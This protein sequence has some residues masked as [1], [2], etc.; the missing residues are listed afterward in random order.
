MRSIVTEKESDSHPGAPRRTDCGPVGS[1]GSFGNT[2]DAGLL[3]KLFATRSEWKRSVFARFL[4]VGISIYLLTPFALR[5][6]QTT[7]SNGQTSGLFQFGE[8]GSDIPIEIHSDNESRFEGGVAI[9]EKNVVIHY[10]EVTLYSDYAE[11][12]VDTK[13]VLLRGNVRIFSRQGK[14]QYAF[15]TDRAVYN[16]DTKE[17]RM[18]SFGGQ[19]GQK[20][21][22]QIVGDT[23]SSSGSNEYIVHNGFF[24]TSDSSTPDYQIRARTMRIYPDDRIILSNATMFVGRTP[25]F[26]FPYLYQSLNDQFSFQLAPGYSS[27]FGAYMLSVVSFPVAKNVEASAHFDLRTSRGPALGLDVRYRLGKNDESFG[28]LQVYG[29]YDTNPNINETSLNRFPIG[30]G[31]YR[32]SYES[33]TYLTDDI[34]VVANINKFSD[35]YFLQDFYPGEFT[36]DPQPDTYLELQKVGEAYTLTALLRPQ[37]NSFQETTERLP[38]LSWE[39][40]RT[41]LFNGPIFYESTTSAAWLHRAFAGVQANPNL[42]AADN[43]N[44]NLLAGANNPDYHTFRFDTFHQILFP[45]TYFGWLSIVPRFGLRATYYENTGTFTESTAA[46]GLQEGT[47]VE[48]GGRVRFAVNAGV[49]ASFKMSRVFEGVQSRL[50]GLDGLRHVIQPY[51][52]F[53]WASSPTVKPNDILPFD[54]FLPSTRLPPIDFP[55][56]VSID[57][58]DRW[59]ILRLGVR[60]RLQTRRDNTTINWLDMD[61]YVDV[62]FDNPFSQ[63]PGSLYSNVFNKLRLSPVPWLSLS[64]DSQLPIL[65]RGFTEVNTYIDWTVNQNLELRVGHRYLWSNPFFTNSSDVIFT[66]YFRLNENWAFS[67]YEDYE[68]ATGVF[69]EQTYTIHRD[70]SSWTAAVGLDRKNDGAGKQ[71]LE[72]FVTFTLKELPHFGIPF[73]ENLG[74]AVGQ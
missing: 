12:N 56:F 51:T 63:F 59:T 35:Q 62:D 7:T 64:V 48:K 6:Q 24:T 46:N 21:P 60:N 40:V 14:S 45:H 18:T 47:L 19:A 15:T 5:A 73:K 34:A 27:T 30:N 44:E 3:R 50:L 1:R 39:V 36:V 17:L 33:R 23:L 11:Y 2:A 28:R 54:R 71:S 74:S 16:L 55:Q 68:A 42:S 49:E 9:A 43:F 38:E 72:L 41:P 52:D 58:L 57:S 29:M 26:W 13:D 61:T 8:K 4:C 70:L 66:G 25:I 32:I 69:N 10:G 37:I 67:I 22:F 31:R 65:D 53:S 20:T